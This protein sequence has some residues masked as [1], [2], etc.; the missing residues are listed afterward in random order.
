MFRLGTIYRKNKW[1][2]SGLFGCITY[3]HHSHIPQSS[4]L[5]HFFNDLKK[6]T[7][8]YVPH[9]S[10]SPKKSI[11]FLWCNPVNTVNYTETRQFY[12]MCSFMFK[13]GMGAGSCVH[14]N[15]HKKE[16]KKKQSRTSSALPFFRFP[17]L[18]Q[19]GTYLLFFNH[20]EKQQTY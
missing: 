5:W 8:V 12:K 6:M 14:L 20:K 9:A 4:I 7:F 15:T 3:L 16:K 19:K 1:N 17:F 18:K 13:W 10:P 2:K 11:W